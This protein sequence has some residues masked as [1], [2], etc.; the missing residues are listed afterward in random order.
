MIIEVVAPKEGPKPLYYSTHIS[1]VLSILSA[2]KV[3]ITY[4]GEG[5]FNYFYL[6]I[7]KIPF[8]FDFSDHT[9]INEN[10]YLSCASYFKFHANFSLLQTYK[11]MKSFSPVSFYDWEQM[12]KL[13]KEIKYTCNN[14]SI[15]NMQTPGGAAY[16]RRIMVQKMLKTR[17]K[18]EVKITPESQ[19]N[20]WNTIKNCL[21]HVYV[22]GAR[23]NM[24][25][26]GHLQCL[27]FGCCTISPKIIDYLAYDRPLLE[28]HH[29]ISCKDDYSDLVDKIEWCKHN[30]KICVEIGKNAQQLFNETS[31]PKKLWESILKELK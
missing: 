11:K 25:D 10:A 29:Y 16:Q 17:Y 13:Q 9:N 18:E 7:N 22:P 26:R 3:A 5:Y 14:N 2:N 6:H 19:I 12:N 31:S 21:V 24:I 15:I 20:Y 8:V 28:N 23:N 4:K 30:R 27:A 1:Y